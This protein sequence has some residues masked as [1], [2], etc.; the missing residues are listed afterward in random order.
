[1]SSFFS[2]GLIARVLALGT[3]AA[4]SCSGGSS[5]CGGGGGC[6]GCGGGTYM[7]P[8]NEPTRPDAIVQDDAV[9][10]RVTQNFLDFIRPQLPSLIASQ[11]GSAGG[12]MYVD[13][14]N[15]L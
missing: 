1:M 15:I 9:R 11:L 6:G 8:Y 5:G 12:G 13:A 7:Y 4:I 14:Q 2:S 3:L 10:V